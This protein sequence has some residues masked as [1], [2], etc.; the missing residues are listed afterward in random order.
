MEEREIIYISNIED[1]QNIGKDPS[2]P[3]KVQY[4]LTQD[5]DASDT[6]N[7]NDGE[8]FAPIGNDY[9][10]PFTGVFDGKGHKIR[11]LYINRPSLDYVGLFG[12]VDSGGQV[13][14]VGLE[15]VQVVGSWRVGGLVGCNYGTVSQS[16]STGS[17]GGNK[18]VGGLVGSNYGTV[19]Q[20]YS[21]GSVEGNQ[22]VGGLVGNNDVGTVGQSYSTGSVAGSY[23]V[24]GL[25]GGNVDTVSRSYSTVS[26]AGNSS[27]GVIVVYKHGG[28]VSQ[29]YWDIETSGQST[30]DWGKGRTTAQMKQQ[31]TYVGW[32]FVNVWAIEENVTYPYLRALGQ[33][34]EP[35]IVEKEI[36]SLSDLNKIGRDREYPMDGH[37]TLMVDIDASATINWDGGKGFKPITLV[38]RF[39][40]NGHV[41]RN[42][43]INRLEEDRV[44]LFSHVYG[45]VKNIG[46]E[47]V[48]VVG[49]EYV[50]GLVGRNY[51]TVSQ[52]YSTGSV[53][54][55]YKVGGLV[56]L[57]RGTVSQS[58]STGSVSGVD[59]VGGL[60]GDNYSG[61]VSQSYSTGSVAGGGSVGGLVGRNEG[62]TVTQSYSTG[63]V[64]GK[65]NVGGLVGVND[66][67]TVTDSYWDK[68]TYGQTVSAGGEG[69]TTAEMKQQATYVGWDFVNVWAIEENVTYPYLRALGQPVEPVIVEKEIWSLSDL[70]KIGRDREYPMDGHYTLM[71]DI[72]ASATIN[73][74]GGKG[75]K[76]ITLV[77]RFDGN[78]HV[79]RNLYINRLE[80]DRV[81]L[82]SHVY[83][84]VK[85][86]GVENVQVVGYEYV[87][88]LV[89][90]NYGTVS[91]SY[92]TGS[93]VGSYK[94]G[95]LVGLNRGTVSQSYSTGS[96]SGVDGVGGLVGDNY[97]GTVS[98][99][100]STGSVAGGGSV[101]GLVGRNEGGTVT[102]SYS[103]G[104][105]S[106]KQNVGGLV[107]VNDGGTVIDS[108]WDKETSGQTTS[109][110]GEGKTTAEMKQQATF[111]G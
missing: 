94:V 92:S 58:Y 31:A 63:S 75:F 88:G 2:Y 69:K 68:E 54:G 73:W 28:T 20:S 40:G 4:E 22:Y 80:E 90:R 103:T 47:N 99:S 98:Q 61:T 82:F 7:W 55:S 87:G 34:V 33:P 50:G 100:Y 108:Y 13:K 64:S 23:D 76:P 53:V 11:N 65:Q 5:I 12:Y 30:S 91:Q 85:N 3:L 49:Y 39:D 21:T 60:V 70:N 67:G 14:N 72:D 110:G 35:V 18:E 42:L 81:G 96:V 102:Q 105:V 83:G 95:G 24:G 77:G 15:N 19:S 57:N 37:Y 97:S 8:G 1:L 51:G 25:V 89:G 71:V 107:G 84:E 109:N 46:V 111:V 17:V 104:S 66:G 27:V 62:G 16:Y 45:E 93:V 101:G 6:I 41:I 86:I 26:V 74:D 106:G 79:I 9:N 44:G 59:G 78:G 48:Q 32:D 52:S 10:Q 36:W 56:G 38:G 29:S 43:Y